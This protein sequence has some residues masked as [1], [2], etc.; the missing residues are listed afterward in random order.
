MSVHV[1]NHLGWQELLNKNQGL[2]VN[3]YVITGW[4]R[5]DH[6]A[7]LCE[8][9]PAGIPSLKCCLIALRKGRFG[10]EEVAEAKQSLGMP[11]I[12]M[13]VYPRPQAIPS[14]CTYFKFSGAEVY[15]LMQRFLNAQ[16]SARALLTHDAMDTWFSAW[17]IKAG[18][19]SLL[20]IRVI[21]NN[22]KIAIEELSY[23][24]KCLIP[25]LNHVFD[26]STA[27]EWIGTY[28]QPL[29]TQL[30]DC[31]DRGT[32]V[33]EQ[34]PPPTRSHQ[35]STRVV[36]FATDLVQEAPLVPDI[37]PLPV[38][39]PEVAPLQPPPFDP[40]YD[41]SQLI[42]TNRSYYGPMQY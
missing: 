37:M 13:E 6:F 23:L 29:M 28:L 8:F 22:V 7:S 33:I 19:V 5:Y 17:Q 38:Q 41:Q 16:A 9:L 20:Q 34:P 1:S 15:V 40:I 18:R 11:D 12:P 32:R 25:V 3:G 36:T 21:V 24:E 42:Q 10:P 26:K 14:D 35:P 2:Q 4:Q 31:R 27:E 30:V 39:Q